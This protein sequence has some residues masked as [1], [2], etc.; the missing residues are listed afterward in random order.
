M[1]IKADKKYRQDF[2]KGTH[3]AARLLNELE[4]RLRTGGRTHLGR[5]G[6]IHRRVRAAHRVP[7]GETAVLENGNW[8]GV[9]TERITCTCCFL[10]PARKWNRSAARFWIRRMMPAASTD[11]N[12]AAKNASNCCASSCGLATDM[13]SWHEHMELNDHTQDLVMVLRDVVQKELKP[14]LSELRAL[15]NTVLNDIKIT[16]EKPGRPPIPKTGTK[17]KPALRPIPYPPL[18]TRYWPC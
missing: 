2:W 6:E 4:T 16:S 7:P 9:L 11:L 3:Q 15:Q 18:R 13:N 14:H 10:L 5:P 12:T 17:L 8:H 1:D